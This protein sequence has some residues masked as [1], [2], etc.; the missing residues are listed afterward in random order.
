VLT[1]AYET[2]AAERL[3]PRSQQA[4]LARQ[5]QAV[6]LLHQAVGRLPNQPRLALQ[7]AYALERV[8][9]PGD[10]AAVVARVSSRPDAGPS[11]RYFYNQWPDA[12][13]AEIERQLVQ[14]G[15][16]RLPRLA[17][18]LAALPAGSSR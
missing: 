9:R 6:G 17:R 10:A 1:I 4:D 2:L 14:A 13:R 8:G 11:P 12:D 5:N 3:R 15:L 18:A 16:V 7:L